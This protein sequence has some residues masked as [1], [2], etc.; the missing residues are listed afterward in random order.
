MNILKHIGLALVVLTALN[1]SAQNEDFRKSGPAPKLQLGNFNDFKLDNGLEVIVVEDDRQKQVSFQLYVDRPIILEGEVAGTSTIVGQML[2]SGTTT[3]DKIQIDEALESISA[4]LISNPNGATV[5]GPSQDAE[6]LLAL[7]ADC[8]QNPTFPEEEFTKVVKQHEAMLTSQKDDS[9]IIVQNLSNQVRFGKE[10]PYGERMTE[11]SL[12]HISANACRNFHNR[13]FRPAISYLVVVGDITPKAAKNLAEAYF[14]EWESEGKLFREFFLF[15]AVPKKRQVDFVAHPT[16]VQSVINVT[17]AVPLKPGSKDAIAA[18][19]LNQILS[20]GADGRLSQN[21]DQDKTL[22]SGTYSELQDDL[23][24]GYF[25]AYAKVRNEV[26]D[27]AV[28]EILAEMERLRNEPVSPEELQQAKNLIN[29]AFSRSRERPEAIAQYALNTALYNLPR[30]YYPNYLQNL[31]KVSIEDVQ[32]VAQIYLKPD[33]AHIV[34]VGDR[35]VAAGLKRFAAGDDI[36]Y[37]GANGEKQ[38]IAGLITREGITAE[39]VLASYIDAIGGLERLLEI[40]DITTV[41]EGEV[42]GMATTMKQEK[43]EGEK[44]HLTVSVSGMAVSET[45]VNGQQAKVLQ[46]GTP[47]EVDEKGLTD[48]RE[49]AIIFPEARYAELGFTTAMEGVEMLGDKK[50]YI[51]RITSPSGNELIEYFDTVSGLKL[52]TITS[53][54]AATITVDYD[55]YREVDGLYYPH[56]VTSSGLMP[57][58]L[59]FTLTSLTVNE[60]LKEDRFK[61][62]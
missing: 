52:R 24:A 62:E 53:S 48:L 22:N 12:E 23:N 57:V 58:P 42:Q 27:S 32:R 55:D 37:F 13:Y 1:L 36:N 46:M 60:G 29:G 45:I 30:N 34:V 9:A 4:D 18:N 35:E 17:Y 56:K 2:R 3:R 25:N 14:G 6:T 20:G 47:Q 11:K 8:I 39:Q 10:H 51:I 15:P 33:Q 43:Q 44:M 41:V 31:A 19:V 16:A 61:V 7:L 21:L 54:E 49:Q 38:E 5:S 50:A 26:A 59:V 40:T 28:H